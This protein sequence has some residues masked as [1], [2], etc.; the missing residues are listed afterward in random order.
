[1]KIVLLV[2]RDRYV[3]ERSIVPLI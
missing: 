1:V 2:K 3:Q